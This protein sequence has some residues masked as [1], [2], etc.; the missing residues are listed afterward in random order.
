[1]FKNIYHNCLCTTAVNRMLC[2]GGQVLSFESKK[3]AAAAAQPEYELSI[4]MTTGMSAPPIDMI[5][6]QPNTSAIT[7]INT[8]SKTWITFPKMILAILTYG[9]QLMLPKKTFNRNF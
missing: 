2:G 1:M 9:G 5:K 7:V 8:K 6:C 4:E 3:P